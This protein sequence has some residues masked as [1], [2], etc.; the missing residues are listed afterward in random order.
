M[1]IMLKHDIYVRGKASTRKTVTKEITSDFIPRIGDSITD[2]AFEKSNEYKVDKIVINY[3][4][5][6]C[7]VQL[8]FEKL[9]KDEENQ[10]NEIVEKY[11]LQK[12]KISN[13][14]K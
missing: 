5:D 4:K 6:L 8:E 14:V 13:K 9:E 7:I 12:W 10:L 1:K 11:L 3:E 2:L